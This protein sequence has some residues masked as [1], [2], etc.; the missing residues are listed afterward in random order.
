[1]SNVIYL[2]A[3]RKDQSVAMKVAIREDAQAIGYRATLDGTSFPN[4]FPPMTLAASLFDD[5][6]DL[7][8]LQARSEPEEGDVASN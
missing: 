6:Y 2:S 4:P 3:V 8:V 7:G 1:M 5:G